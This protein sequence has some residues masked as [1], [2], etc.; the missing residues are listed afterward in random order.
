VV[1][2]VVEVIVDQLVQVQ[3]EDLVA[4]V[5]K[6]LTLQ[7]PLALQ[8]EEVVILLQLVHHKEIMVVL[9]VLLLLTP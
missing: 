1:A 7:D 9:V 6:V 8:Q 3:M 4:A 2:V 5:E